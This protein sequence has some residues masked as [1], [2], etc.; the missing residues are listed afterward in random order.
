MAVGNTGGHSKK[1]GEVRSTTFFQIKN[2]ERKARDIIILPPPKIQSTFRLLTVKNNKM[3][4]KFVSSSEN[5]IYMRNCRLPRKRVARNQTN[6]LRKIGR[7]LYR[8]LFLLFALFCG[9]LFLLGDC[10]VLRIKIILKRSCPNQ[11]IS[12]TLCQNVSR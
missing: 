5:I 1:K 10:K 4:I 6:S 9:L 3:S 11:I 8:P 7:P 12:K 2:W